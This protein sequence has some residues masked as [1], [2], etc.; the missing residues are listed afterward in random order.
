MK[1][2]AKTKRIPV[3]ELLQIRERTTELEGEIARLKREI[4]QLRAVEAALRESEERFRS[5]LE[6]MN[7]GY[8]VIQNSTIAFANNR[9]AQMFGYTQGS[10]IGKIIQD[11]LPGGD[12]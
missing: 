1:T 5:F 2:A 6:E 10:V 8:C 11:F 12:Y 3:E 7:D 4:T 9:L